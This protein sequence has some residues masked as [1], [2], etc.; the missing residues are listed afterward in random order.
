MMKYCKTCA[1]FDENKNMCALSGLFMDGEKDYCSK[2]ADV[3]LHCDVCGNIML[4][5]GSILE[6]D[7]NGECHQFCARCAE[8]LKT[9]QACSAPCEFETNPDPMPKVVMKTVRQGNMQMQTQIMNPERVEKFCPSCGCYDQEV[10]CKRQFNVG[11]DKK[12][13]FWT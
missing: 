1:Y 12:T 9:C 4:T 5:S 3:L 2:H 11:C 8:L 13:S 10:G 7:S 6:I